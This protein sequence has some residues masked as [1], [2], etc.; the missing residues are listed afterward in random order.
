MDARD[1]I[2][3]RLSELTG[4]SAVENPIGGLD[5]TVDGQP[6]VTGRQAGQLAITSG[7]N[8][9]GPPTVPPSASP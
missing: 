2:A 3:L 6:L 5:V 9:T 4:G 7:V 1:Q 8:P